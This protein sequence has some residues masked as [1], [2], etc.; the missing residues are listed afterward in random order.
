MHSATIG[1]RGCPSSC[2]QPRLQRAL[3]LGLGRR[4]PSHAARALLPLP[5]LFTCLRTSLIHALGPRPASHPRTRPPAARPPA[6]PQ[7]F[8]PYVFQVFAQLIEV[9]RPGEKLPEVYLSIFPPLLTP[10]FWERAGN[11][12]A[13]V[14]LLQVGRW[15]GVGGAG[16]GAGRHGRAGF[17]TV[18]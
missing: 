17:G 7:E 15:G 12:P 11:I 8:H 16:H 4:L 18:G 14:R 13:L 10:V 5:A 1:W 6:A 3:L 2:R 9:R